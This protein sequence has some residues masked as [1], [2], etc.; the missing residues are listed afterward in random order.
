MWWI[1]GITF[2]TMVVLLGSGFRDLMSLQSKKAYRNSEQTTRKNGFI[3]NKTDIIVANK[4]SKYSGGEVQEA[5]SWV[6]SLTPRNWHNLV[7]HWDYDMPFDTILAWIL[8]HPDCDKGTAQ[9]VLSVNLLEIAEH[10]FDEKDESIL[11]FLNLSKAT[12]ERLYSDSYAT[13]QFLP[14]LQNLQQDYF[15]ALDI[16]ERHYLNSPERY[17]IAFKKEFFMPA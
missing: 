4:F 8:S 15:R 17:S 10:G 14:Y 7:L 2:A 1:I 12:C 13:F 11:F 3:S 5:L 16:S 6:K 9:A